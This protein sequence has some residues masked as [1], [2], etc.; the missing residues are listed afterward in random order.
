M[1]DRYL[2]RQIGKY[3]VIRLL[4][5][6]AFAWVYEAIDQDLEIPVAL[7][8][9]RPEFSGDAIAE[10]RFRRE[11]ST[12]ARL[13][14]PHIVV[15][16]D[17]GQI[18]GASFVAMD[19]LSN[20]LGQRLR[21]TRALPEAEVVRIGLDVASALAVAHAAGVIHRDI[22]PDNI[23]FGPAG[24]AVV[25]DFGLARALS[26]G[27]GLSATNQV[28]GTPHYFSPEQARGLE[29][30]GRSDLYSLGVTLYRT[31][32]GKL[33]FDGDDWYAVG[34]QHI[35][36]APLPPR[37]I[38][39]SLSRELEE[40]LLQLLAK[41]PADR[42]PSGEVLA[43]ALQ[44]VPTR[45]GEREV[46]SLTTA[47]ATAGPFTPLPRNAIE[48]HVPSRPLAP[49]QLLRRRSA[50]RAGVLATGLLLGVVALVRAT[51]PGR[52]W[53]RTFGREIVAL[54]DSATLNAERMRAAAMA[55][56]SDSL[57]FDSARADVQRDSLLTVAINAAAKPTAGGLAAAGLR[58]GAPGVVP[59]DARARLT[60][61]SSD[62]A[63]LFVDG[64]SVG[65]GSWTGDHAAARDVEVRAVLADAPAG[66]TAA[67][68]DTLVRLKP[69]SRSTISL[70]VRSCASLTVDV[71]PRDAHLIFTPLDGGT[72][73]KV[74]AD[75]ASGQLLVAGKYAVVA[76]L[77]RCIAFYD[78]VVSAPRTVTDS[79]FLRARMTCS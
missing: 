56:L 59:L 73:L 9:L 79:V 13:R 54:S 21:T 70:A 22:K 8:I 35:D 60:I 75:S 3:R 51:D 24:E 29:L 33:P 40:I 1:P 64:Q 50:L 37:D 58:K 14:H 43:F 44:S 68:R 19:L 41:Q 5:G 32:T 77:P 72:T 10:A 67:T 66:C 6:G 74:R 76:T 15:V 26:Q 65:T 45:A 16:R 46:T 4:G 63:D 23:L 7:K 69:G 42:Y 62:D 27:V 20:S 38:V 30:D 18:E 52:V 78:T 57:A 12:A 61:N 36:D 31:A 55:R 47:S 2:G 25:A 17:V 71:L 48:V 53:S 11:A 28:M 49:G 34:R 39:P